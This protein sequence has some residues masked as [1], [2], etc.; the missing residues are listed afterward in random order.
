MRNFYQNPKVY[1]LNQKIHAFYA[2]KFSI[3]NYL[4]TVITAFST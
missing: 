4:P 3:E 2:E 1:D